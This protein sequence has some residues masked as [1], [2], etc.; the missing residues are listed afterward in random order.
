MCIC[1]YIYPPCQDNSLVLNLFYEDTLFRRGGAL[2]IVAIGTL[3]FG[4]C[5]RKMCLEIIEEGRFCFYKTGY[6]V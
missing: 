6:N 4:L 2:K 3:K 1:M 5:M